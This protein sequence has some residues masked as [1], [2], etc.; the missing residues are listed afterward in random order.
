[1]ALRLDNF[2]CM[3]IEFEKVKIQKYLKKFKVK[4]EMENF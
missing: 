4:K 3:I 2:N 1:M